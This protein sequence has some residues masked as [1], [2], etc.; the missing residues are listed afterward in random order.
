[1]QLEVIGKDFYF[2]FPFHHSRMMLRVEEI[3]LLKGFLVGRSRIRVTL[4][5]FANDT[6]FF[7]RASMEDLQNLKLILLVFW[8]ISRLKI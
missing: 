5:Q 4:L 2:S 7:S 3:G 1:M 6:I 8:H